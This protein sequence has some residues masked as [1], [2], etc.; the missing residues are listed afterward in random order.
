MQH[1]ASH[2][3]GPQPR[4]GPK[5]A[6]AGS[7]HS[8]VVRGDLCYSPPGPGQ[9][10]GPGPGPGLGPGPGRLGDVDASASTGSSL[11]S[12]GRRR[13]AALGASPR[14]YAFLLSLALPLAAPPQPSPPPSLSP[15]AHRAAP[16]PLAVV[17]CEFRVRALLR[18]TFARAAGDLAFF[19]PQVGGPHRAP[20][21]THRG[22]GG[23]PPTCPSPTFLGPAPSPLARRGGPAPDAC[24]SAYRGFACFMG[25]ELLSYLEG[26]KV[27]TLPLVSPSPRP[28][29]GKVALSVVTRAPTPFDLSLT[30]FTLVSPSPR[31]RCRWSCVR[32]SGGGGWWACIALLTPQT[33][34]NPPRPGQRPVPVPGPG[35]RGG[36]ATACPGRHDWLRGRRSGR[37]GWR[38]WKRRPAALPERATQA[39]PLPPSR[40]PL[41]PGK[42]TQKPYVRR[43]R[44]LSP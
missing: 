8:R 21:D 4:A 17:H 18:P 33:A 43:W 23:S 34:T 36:G 25:P 29:G 1:T 16:A 22:G 28:R 32:A 13:A 24:R 10:P 6:G 7:Q 41:W 37:R 15:S 12:G 38:A 27:G 26:G 31:S 2:L 5:G 14:G 3:A 44:R 9:G 11:S 20:P 30:H 40:L 42:S 35:P 19:A 39:S